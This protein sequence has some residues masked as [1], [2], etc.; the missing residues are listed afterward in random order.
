MITAIALVVM[1]AAPLYPARAQQA[2]STPG[3]TTNSWVSE[4]KESVNTVGV[5]H[6]SNKAEEAQDA[7]LIAKVKTA[8]ATNGVANGH[9]VEVDCDRGVA[10]LSGVVGSAGAAKRAAQIAA[11]VPGVVGVNN[12]LTWR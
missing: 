9:P 3:T 7:L 2:A 10:R 1:A 6:Y 5:H 8:L 11:A 12:Q 4:K